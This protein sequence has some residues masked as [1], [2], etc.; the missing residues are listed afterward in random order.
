MQL[1]SK[2]NKRIHF[3]LCVTDIYSTY[4]CLVPLKDKKGIAITNAFQK[5]LDESG[6]K[7]NKSKFYSRSIK[8]YVKSSPYIDPVKKIMKKILNLKLVTMEEYKNIKT[9][10]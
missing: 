9:F 8:S 10:F 6:C 3:L 5:I 4:A 2:F 7:P 1:L